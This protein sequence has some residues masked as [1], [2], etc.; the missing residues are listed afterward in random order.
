MKCG[1]LIRAKRASLKMTRESLS[2]KSGVSVMTIRRY[3]SSEREPRLDIIEK[4][5]GALGC[6]IND[7]VEDLDELSLEDQTDAI[8]FGGQK[9]TMNEMYDLLDY[10]T[11]KK[12]DTYVA[13]ML[14]LHLLKEEHEARTRQ[15]KN[16]PS[17]KPEP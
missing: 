1:E 14:A 6:T 10:E 15:R 4:L 11:K 5:A 16:G 3:E 13:D 8:I 17:G 2:E 9:A 7:L 12:V